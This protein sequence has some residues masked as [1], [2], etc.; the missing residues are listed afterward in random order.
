MH[1]NHKSYFW[2]LCVLCLFVAVPLPVIGQ[3]DIHGI[4]SNA[5]IIPLERPKEL[6]GKQ[7]FTREELAAYEEKLFVRTTRDRPPAPGSVGTYND[8]WWDRDARRALNL[9]TSIIVDP[10]DGKV[11][12]LTPQAQKRLEAERLRAREHPC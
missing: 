8:F 4:W 9:R 3:A 6:E 10:S 1:K 2:F 7:F 5:S 12:P 11:P